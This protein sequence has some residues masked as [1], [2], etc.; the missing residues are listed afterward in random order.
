MLLHGVLPCSLGLR[1]PHRADWSVHFSLDGRARIARQDFLDT[2][3]C[4]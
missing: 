1:H 3:L 4:R 2:D